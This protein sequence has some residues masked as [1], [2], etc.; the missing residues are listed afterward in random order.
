MVAS[1]LEIDAAKEAESIARNIEGLVAANSAEGVIVG[2]S[3]GMD[4]AVLA[5]L[6]VRAVGKEW[7]GAYYLYDRDSSHNS[8]AVAKLVA[9]WLG[10][11]LKVEDITGA[12][13]KMGI[14]SPMVMRVTALSGFMNRH[15]NGRL[16]RLLWGEPFFIHTLRKGAPGEKKV[17]RFFFERIVD[18]VEAAFNARHMYRRQFLEGTSD[19][20]NRL[21][22]G[23]ANRSEWLVGW[24][25]KG[26]IDDVPLS[27]LIRLYK[28]K[29]FKLA[30][31]LELPAGIRNQAPS[32][33]MMKG[34]TDECA[35]GINYNTLD[36]ILDCIDRG[37]SDEEIVAR[38]IS[39]KDVR[40]VRTMN[41]LSRWKR[42]R[43]CATY[44]VNETK[45]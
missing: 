8:Q 29:V 28:T 12:M 21:V 1:V 23:A 38:G 11:E 17:K 24:F 18:S 43:E 10:I 2:L 14:Y 19:E 4:S 25:V 20:Q 15:L 6:A 42:E 9:D 13:R 27:P 39:R 30:E 45:R 44:P 31:Y 34:I 35:L 33:D 36:I 7:V 3:G 5:T 37:V 40:L 16:H 26:E 32:P 22:L 41:D